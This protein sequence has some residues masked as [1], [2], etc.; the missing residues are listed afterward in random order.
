MNTCTCLSSH[1]LYQTPI[2]TPVWNTEIFLIL[3]SWGGML[4]WIWHQRTN[5]ETFV[6]II[7]VRRMGEIDR[8]TYRYCVCF[9]SRWYYQNNFL[10]MPQIY[11]IKFKCVI[12]TTI[13]CKICITLQEISKFP[14]SSLCK[15]ICKQPDFLANGADLIDRRET[16]L[17]NER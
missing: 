1:T 17:T 15:Q 13:H 16:W 10:H 9:T 4:C 11:S 14:F 6:S 12:K 5:A 3:I 8:Q 7:A 2:I